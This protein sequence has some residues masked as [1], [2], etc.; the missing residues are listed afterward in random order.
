MDDSQA[1]PDAIDTESDLNVHTA[2]PVLPAR[3]VSPVPVA[4]PAPVL[5]APAL[6]AV[7]DLLHDS[8]HQ[9][10]N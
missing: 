4:V 5:P 7:P 9:P 6:A 2:L 1:F 8:L 10:G 3:P